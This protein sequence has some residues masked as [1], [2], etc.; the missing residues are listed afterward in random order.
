MANR[1]NE[2]RLMAIFTR[3]STKVGLFA[4]AVAGLAAVSTGMALAADTVPSAQVEMCMADDDP[5]EL[6]V[7]GTNQN[8]DTVTETF[9]GDSCAVLS[10][11]GTVYWWALG[12]TLNVVEGGVPG[13]IT[14]RDDP[15]L[16]GQKFTFTVNR[17]RPDGPAERAARPDPAE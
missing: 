6:T 17:A 7:T 3:R 13:R 8:G 4:A 5:W 2:E 14:L 9:S 12:T 15:D 16:D 1:V 10:K 11:D